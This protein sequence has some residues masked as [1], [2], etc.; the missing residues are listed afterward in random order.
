M[1]AQY[2]LNVQYDIETMRAMVTYGDRR[3]SLP[4]KYD[5]LAEARKAAEAYAKRYLIKK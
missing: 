1:Q 4:G 3:V 2:D 5:D